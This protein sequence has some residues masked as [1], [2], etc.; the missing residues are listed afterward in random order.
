MSP[1]LEQQKEIIRCLLLCN[2]FWRNIRTLV[3]SIII[4]KPSCFGRGR[5]SWLG[6]YPLYLPVHQRSNDA[7]SRR[8]YK[9]WELISGCRNRYVRLV[10][11]S[12]ENF[13]WVM[14]LFNVVVK[15]KAETSTQKHNR[16][17]SGTLLFDSQ[18]SHSAL[19][20]I[21]IA[22]VVTSRM[23]FCSI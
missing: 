18:V 12:A 17:P 4:Q 2:Y 14:I 6:R 7:V 1:D 9:R 23:T 21:C 22:R 15:N 20:I 5:W 16:T 19:F 13:M 3:I 8:P 10:C 11:L